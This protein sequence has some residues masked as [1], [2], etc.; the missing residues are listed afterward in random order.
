[1]RTKTFL[2][3]SAFVLFLFSACETTY[4][5]ED[6]SQKEKA[7]PA[8]AEHDHDHSQAG[9]EMPPAPE[10]ARVYFA[11]LND[12][13]EIKS[14]VFIEFGLEGIDL[15]PAGEVKEGSGHHHLLINEEPTP[16]GIAVPADETHI[17]Y[18]GGQSSDTLEL[19]MGEHTLV[20]QFADGIHRSYGE[21][22]SASI[23]VK[24]VD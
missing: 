8:K 13:D 5:R 15:D 22:L 19:P 23:R 3:I 2:F 11:N 20:L 10:D 14:P 6:S 21:S 9:P 12:G 18:G 4:Q 24:V 1:M 17:H 16:F 7:E